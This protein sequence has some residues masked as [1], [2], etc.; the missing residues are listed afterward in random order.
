MAYTR[1]EDGGL[2]QDVS[3]GGLG[4][5]LAGSV[6]DHLASDLRGPW[7]TTKTVG[8]STLSNRQ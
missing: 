3:D 6:A 5:Q 1:G 2:T 4:G 8:C 7:P